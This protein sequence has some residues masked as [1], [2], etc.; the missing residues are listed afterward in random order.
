MYFILLKET[1]VNPIL[2]EAEANG[3]IMAEANV[4]VKKDYYK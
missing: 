4:N 3:R 1:P 2:R